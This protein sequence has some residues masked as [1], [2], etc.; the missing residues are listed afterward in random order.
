[1]AWARR[2]AF[3]FNI[4]DVFPDA[5]VA[6]GAISNRAVIAVA[7]WLERWSYRR[8]DA[9]TVLSTDLQANVAGKL[10]SAGAAKVCT[11][12]NFVD[13]DQIAPADRMT[14]YRS[15]LG[16]GPEP[17]VL[18]AGNI[19]YSQTLELLI[20]LA[21]RRPDLTVLINGDGGARADLQ[22]AAADLPNVRFAGYV[23]DERLVELLATGDVHAVPLR[24]GLGS[25]SVPSKTYSILAA[26]RPIVAAIDAG[27]EVPRILDASGA[28]VAVEPDD[29]DA[30]AH[31]VGQLVD[32][33]DGARARGEAGRRWVLTAASPGAVAEEYERLIE[34]LDRTRRLA[35]EHRR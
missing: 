9:V 31:A 34:S 20:E 35:G 3:V 23:P 10:P 17:V 27:T 25:V 26:G 29:A 14:P 2:A 18:Y 32:D 11:I 21:R 16:I 33:P 30:F 1:V 5:A 8:A 12:P 22:A 6:T 7:R 4:Q 19:G 15:Q 28:G 24:R 13:T